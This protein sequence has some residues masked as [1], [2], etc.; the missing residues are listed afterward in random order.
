[1]GKGASRR[2]RVW[3]GEKGDIFSILLGLF[4]PEEKSPIH[5]C[6]GD[7]DEFDR[8]QQS[9]HDGIGRRWIQDEMETEKFWSLGRWG[10]PRWKEERE[11]QE[12]HHAVKK[13]DIQL[14][15]RYFDSWW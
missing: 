8:Q 12:S 5:S 3:A 4:L 13:L 10:F 1:M 6:N 11:R 9:A 2:A 7:C 15:W 14:T